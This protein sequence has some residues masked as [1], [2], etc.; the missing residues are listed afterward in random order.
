MKFIAKPVV[1]EAVQYLG[2]ASLDEMTK[3]WEREFKVHNHGVENNICGL[4]W[5]SK[6][7]WIIKG[8]EG[9]FYS[10]KDSF[11]RQRFDQIFENKESGE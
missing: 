1:I 4:V 2:P 5:C 9:E 3:T 8:I 7:D 6:T 10:C 11:F